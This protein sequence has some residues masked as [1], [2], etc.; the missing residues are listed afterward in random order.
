MKEGNCTE[1]AVYV[2]GVMILLFPT[3]LQDANIEFVI[4]L[5][6]GLRFSTS[7]LPIT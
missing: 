3:L 6:L 1:L 2:S 5:I 7:L 4:I